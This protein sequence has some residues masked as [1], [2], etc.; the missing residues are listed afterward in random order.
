MCTLALINNGKI[1]PLVF[2]DQE[3]IDQLLSTNGDG[4][5]TTDISTNITSLTD[6]Y[7][8]PPNNQK[9]IITALQIWLSDNGG[10]DA[11][12]YGNGISLSNGMEVYHWTGSGP[13]INNVTR[14]IPVKTNG[15]WTRNATLTEESQY[16]SGANYLSWIISFTLG[17]QRGIVLDGSSGERL[18][19]LVGIDNYSGL[20]SHLFIPHGYKEDI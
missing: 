7:I 9:Y 17:G 20:N 4:T 2:G 14:G 15:D 3:H 1:G 6:V 18:S 8:A 13:A 16:G 12:D 19:V 11:G 10:L 5:G